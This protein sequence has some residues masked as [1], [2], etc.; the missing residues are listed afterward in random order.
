MNERNID[1][2]KEVKVKLMA[3]MLREELERLERHVELGEVSTTWALGEA[4]RRGME[5][6]QV[7]YR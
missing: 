5:L 6:A 2:L 4:A 3:E 1:T 7:I